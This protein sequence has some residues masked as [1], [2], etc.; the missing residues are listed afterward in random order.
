ERMTQA[1]D[2]FHIAGVSHNIPFLAAVIAT[3]RFR[4][5]ALSTSFIAD[6]FPAGFAGAAIGA[7]SEAKAVAVAAAAQRIVAER[8][9]LIGG[10]I[11]G[12]GRLVPEAWTVC[13]G[14]ARQRVGTVRDGETIVVTADD[15][16]YRIVS[17]W[18]PWQPI[19]ESTV[20]GVTRIYQIARAGIGLT[21]SHAGWSLELK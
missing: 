9:A 16:V 20:D 4:A 21:L 14:A 13:R 5:G 3:E 1:L 15:A 18:Q 2:S 12:R 8:E 6:E 17:R 19:F 10:Q 11:A 7:K